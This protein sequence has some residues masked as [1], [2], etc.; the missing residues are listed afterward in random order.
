M[1]KYSKKY[2]AKQIPNSKLLEGTARYAGLLLAPAEGFGHCPRFFCP[3]G[4]RR[5]FNAVCAYFGPFLV[6][7]SNLH[8]V[9]KTVNKK[10]PKI[11]KTERKKNNKKKIKKK[12]H[13]FF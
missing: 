12:K 4:N 1:S 2:I 6:F 9:S 13:N 8:K 10:N 7:S 3:W 11:P 5:A